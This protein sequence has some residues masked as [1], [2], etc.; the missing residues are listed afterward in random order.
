MAEPDCFATPVRP[1]YQAPNTDCRSGLLGLRN[2]SREG[3]HAMSNTDIV[4][5]VDEE[6]RKE[7]MEK[8]WEQYR[9]LILTAAVLVVLVVAGYKGWQGYR[10]SQ[11]AAAGSK[12]D[13]A[14][15]L[16]QA[17][18]PDDAAKALA[19][20]ASSGSGAYPVLAQL[21][22]AAKAAT[23]GKTDE[24]LVQYDAIANGSGVDTT[25]RGLARIDAA[26]LRLDK[27]DFTAMQNQLNDL[28]MPEGTWRNS[29]R[30]LLGLS[31]Y[32]AGKLTEADDY[33]A[34]ILADKDGR[35]PVGQ[36]AEMMRELILAA[37]AKPP[38]T[39]SN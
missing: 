27:S 39:K 4:R 26:Q 8:L 38:V 37:T 6:L 10:A 30:E 14:V 31:A 36:M 35:G 22:L 29:A 25:L 13:A 9:S 28:A 17:G 32:K 33:F 3:R 1:R 16:A 18:K 12:F 21:R 5:E 20:V 19:D 2:I 7:Q 34:S 11:A 24:A 23:D 15:S